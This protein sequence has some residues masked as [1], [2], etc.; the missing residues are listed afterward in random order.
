MKIYQ[1]SG[2]SAYRYHSRKDKDIAVGLVIVS[3]VEVDENIRAVS[4]LADVESVWI[5][6]SGVVERIEIRNRRGRQNTLELLLKS[7][8][9]AGTNCK[10][11][12]LLMERQSVN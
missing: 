2:R 4:V 9:S 6:L 10:E 8:M 1:R 11:S 7:V 5:G 3:A 12:F